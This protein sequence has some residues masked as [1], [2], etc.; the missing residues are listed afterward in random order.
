ME[1]EIGIFF[2]NYYKSLEEKYKNNEKDYFL[3][4][5]Q[6]KFLNECNIIQYGEFSPLNF[7]E[8]GYQELIPNYNNYSDLINYNK[9]K[10]FSCRYIYEKYYSSNEITFKIFELFKNVLLNNKKL[11][12]KKIEKLIN[13]YNNDAEKN[14]YQYNKY[15]IQR[16]ID[17]FY[18]F[19]L[20]KLVI[21][22]LSIF[23]NNF[24][25]LI[26]NKNYHYELNNK[27]SILINN[28]NNRTGVFDEP[29]RIN[30]EGLIHNKLDNINYHQYYIYLING[31][32]NI[33]FDIYSEIYDF[34]VIFIDLINNDIKIN[35]KL[36][37]KK[38]IKEKKEKVIKENKVKKKKKSIPPSLK[39][40]VWNKH[41]GDEI[42][43]TKCLCCKLQDIYQASFSCGHIIA[44]SNGG[45]LKLN[46]LKPICSSCNSSMGTKNMNEYIEEFGF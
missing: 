43:K 28:L 19:S 9:N 38:I 5:F 2:E 23:K 20:N 34:F 42:G 16:L 13:M 1:K 12:N 41:I 10:Y 25:L 37:N 30:F 40:K 29:F 15:I 39:I 46:N 21:N 27:I 32:R 8:A 22:I 7:N 31:V 44:E 45:E 18:T 4:S 11:N 24:E 36:T 35:K 6:L 33:S 3:A 17:K 26:N 14:F